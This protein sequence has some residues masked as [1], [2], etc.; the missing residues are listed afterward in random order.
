MKRPD[1][2]TES[3]LD[4]RHTGEV[5]RRRLAD[6]IARS[7][8][9]RSAFAARVGMDRSSL[10]QLLNARGLRLPRT[11]TVAAM[12]VVG[13]VSADWLLGL[14]QDGRVGT[15]V[16][17]LGVEIS[18][19]RSTPADRRLAAWHAE[20]AGYKIRY[21]PATLPDLLK[22]E[23]VIRYEFEVHDTLRPEGRIE[24]KDARL[25]YSRRPDTDMEVCSSVQS[26]QELARGEGI[27]RELPLAARREQ[28][29]EMA[30]L[31]DELYPTL[32]WFLYDG[33]RR[34]ST[35]L[36][37][38]GPLRA[39]V[40]MGDMYLVFNTTEH[41]RVLSRHFDELIRA[42]VMQPTEVMAYVRRLSTARG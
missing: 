39:V 24:E 38:F 18:P 2:G 36:T 40:Y 29:A 32:R 31:L 42:A 12:A 3:V 13:Q 5:F 6:T 15:D 19:G 34:Y 17:D 4:K 25:E 28:L 41:I 10:S 11:E 27:W 26:L 16:V 30:R 9:S 7:G 14:S 23:A 33:R 22:T 35:P 8:M 1:E 21:V 20:A 37:V